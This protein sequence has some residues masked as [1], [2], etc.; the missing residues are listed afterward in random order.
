M[1]LE[2]RKIMRFILIDKILKIER[3]KRITAG[4]SIALSE[5]VFRDHFVGYPVM[6][7]SLMI[8]SVAQAATALLEI[9]AD[10]K[11]KAI[12]TIVEKAKFRELIK[13]G[14]T[15]VIN[16]NIIS[17]QEN[18]ALLEGY[19]HLGEKLVMDCKLVFV[20]KPV[21]IFYPQKVRAFMDSIYEY[22]LEGAELIGFK[23]E[24]GEI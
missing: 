19:I 17:V 23:S 11:M 24:R 6:P 3:D 10:Y 13:P 7:G 15:I 20:L 12:L 8:E 2:K 4:K 21:D 22:W 16:V 5:E 9:S 14:I 1:F 18:S